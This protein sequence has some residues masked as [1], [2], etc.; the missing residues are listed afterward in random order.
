MLLPS[1]RDEVITIFYAHSENKFGHKE[2]VIDHL[3]AVARLSKEFASSWNGEIE[4]EITGLF[5]DVGKY[6]DTFQKVLDKEAVHVDHATPGAA[7][8]MYRYKAA[9]MAAAL[10]IQG[11]HEGLQSGALDRLGQSISMKNQ[12]SIFGKIYSSREYT[13]LLD[14]L[15]DEAEYVPDI[16][17]SDYPDLYKNG[18]NIPA[19]MYVRMLFSALT[20]ADFLATEAHF[21]G[22]QKGMVYRSRGRELNP[23]EAYDK[24]LQYKRNIEIESKANS[25]MKQLRNDLFESCINS[26]N[27]SKGLFT[28]TAPTGS[29]KTLAMLGFALK[30]AIHNKMRRIIVVLP[31]LNIIEQTAG[32]YRKIFGNSNDP[33]YIFED[34]S[35]VEAP[36]GDFT[37]LL[38]EN[39][40]APIIITTT[41]KFFESMFS[42][43]SSQC[44][45]LH[46]ISNSIILFDEVQTMPVQLI[47]STLSA[48]TS[49]CKRFGCSIVFSTATQPAFDT[50]NEFISKDSELPWKPEEIVNSK[51][52]LFD[53]ARRVNI[54]WHK[55]RMPWDEIAYELGKTPQNL[56]IVNLRAHAQQLY[57]KT[58]SNCSDVFHLSTNM[59]PAHRIDTLNEVEWRLEHNMPCHLI[60]T[61]C[62]EAG[63][64]LDFPSVWRTMAPLESVIQAAGRCN[65]NGR[66][67]GIVHVFVPELDEEKYPGE[68]YKK[69]AVELKMMLEDGNIDICDV[70]AIRE[71][72]NRYFKFIRVGEKNQKLLDAIKCLNFVDVSKLYRWI[73]SGGINV[74]VPYSPKIDVFNRLREAGLKREISRQWLSDAR[75]ISVDIRLKKESAIQNY[76]VEVKNYKDEGTGYFILLNESLYSDKTGLDVMGTGGEDFYIST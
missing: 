61:Q 69:G 60:S 12:T 53:R 48:L 74:L 19:M 39:W 10:A 14:R 17:R 44:R 16:L 23:D 5:H 1:V 26:A 21:N 6:S 8:V 29:G 66:G 65:R 55:E 67:D 22:N 42:N 37:G 63:V 62:V 41:V 71:Y 9:A 18:K 52:N 38:A 76:L 56:A 36:D 59:C 43:R 72:Y 15:L 24:L 57:E 11:H 64:D 46:N 13:K 27:Q 3:K 68:D 35:L 25:D 45:K 70:G 30:H 49:L 40:D 47:I 32:I 33:S 73:P 50:L 2:P 58:L 31:F 75:M 28:L 7:A 51:L 34:H 54:I 20:D 4:G